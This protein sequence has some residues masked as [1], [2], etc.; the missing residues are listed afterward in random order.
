[1]ARI[2]IT[3]GTGFVGL[4]TSRALAEAGHEL[5]LIARGHRRGPRPAG[6]QMVRADVVSGDGLVDALR[7]SDVVL[8]LVAVIRERGSQTFDRVNRQGAENVAKAAREAGVGHIVHL[9]AIG[10]DPDPSYPYLYTK[11]QGE[12]AMVASAVPYDVLRPSLMFGIGDGFFTQ[13]VKLIRW[14]PVVPVP[15]DGRAMFQPLAVT[16]LARIVVQCVETGPQ[17]RIAEIGGPDW[18][19]LEEIVNVI[20]G[21]MHTRKPNV[22]VPVPAILPAAILFDALLPHPPVTPSQLKM[23]AKNNTTHLDA[24]SQQF[25]FQP[26]SFPDNAYYLQDY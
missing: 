13:L 20:K 3:G 24:V 17:R 21:V 11:W 23:L 2:A 7:G 4:H 10:A 1:V 26:Q 9:S 8:H 6:A 18:L 19:S 25:G 5:R 15:G 22:H 14:N 16:D 12:Q